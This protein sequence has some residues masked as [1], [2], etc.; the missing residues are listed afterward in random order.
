MFA[1]YVSA[2]GA[3]Y[4]VFNGKAFSPQRHGGKTIEHEGH[5]GN[6]GQK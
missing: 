3:R 4:P 5:E 1:A 6:E 2:I